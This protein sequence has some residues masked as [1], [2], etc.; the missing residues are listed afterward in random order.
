M[1]TK[2]PITL[3]KKEN[4]ILPHIRTEVDPVAGP[5]RWSSAVRS[6]V[7]EFQKERRD[8]ILPAFERLFNKSPS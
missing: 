5:N 1:H 4:R 7:V 2:Q 8:E 6:W 3:V